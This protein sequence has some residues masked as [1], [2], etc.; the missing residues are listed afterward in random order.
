MKKI[1]TQENDILKEIKQ[2]FIIFKSL[3]KMKFFIAI[4]L[5]VKKQLIIKDII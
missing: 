2:R 1:E 5:Y 3:I 4:K